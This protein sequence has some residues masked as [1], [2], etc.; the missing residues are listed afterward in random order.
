MSK[1]K[2]LVSN[3]DLQTFS[4]YSERVTVT[5]IKVLW[6]KEARQV[7]FARSQI[8]DGDNYLTWSVLSQLCGGKEALVGAT[9]LQRVSKTGLGRE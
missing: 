2:F 6:T 7:R 9:R 3:F 5:L 8:T 1:P 4:I